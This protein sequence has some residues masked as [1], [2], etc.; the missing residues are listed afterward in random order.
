MMVHG[1]LRTAEQW[2]RIEDEREE[3]AKQ[4]EREAQLEAEENDMVTYHGYS[5]SSEFAEQMIHY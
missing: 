1:K 5:V 2:A 4:A 3:M